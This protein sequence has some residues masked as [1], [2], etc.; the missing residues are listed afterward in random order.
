MNEFAEQHYIVKVNKDWDITVTW[1]WNDKLI[2]W[3]FAQV[4]IN[5]LWKLT[6]RDKK[7]VKK[8]LME[9]ISTT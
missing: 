4:V 7:D 9:A 8:M 6:N 5:E 2:L 1:N 3:V